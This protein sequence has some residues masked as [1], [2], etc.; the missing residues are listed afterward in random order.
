M[1]YEGIPE[2]WEDMG[3]TL[4]CAQGACARDGGQAEGQRLVLLSF[5]RSS[6]KA[7]WRVAVGTPA[8]AA[9]P[10]T[11]TEDAGLGGALCSSF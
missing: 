4:R 9:V 5:C 7:V 1:D 6:P 2:P 11:G 10:L 3:M 8:F